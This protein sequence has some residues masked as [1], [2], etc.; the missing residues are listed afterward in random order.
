[1]WLLSRLLTTICKSLWHKRAKD[2]EDVI[3]EDLVHKVDDDIRRNVAL[4]NEPMLKQ[5][6]EGLEH[7]HRAEDRD[8]R[9]DHAVGV[10]LRGVLD[11]LFRPFCR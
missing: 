11:P 6:L 8:R 10:P 2:L 4:G 5:G 7:Q 1:M 3:P 9:V